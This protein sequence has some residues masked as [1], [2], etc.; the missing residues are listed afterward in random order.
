MRPYLLG[1]KFYIHTDQKSLKH[2]LEQC[3]ATPDQ[4]KW[5]TKLLGYDYEIVYKIGK[6]N[7]TTDAL[8]QVDGNPCLN[9]LFIPQASIW[10]TI[11]KKTSEHP[12][13]IRISKEAIEQLREPYQLRNGL[14]FCK[15]HVVIPPNSSII[16]QVLHEYHD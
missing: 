13:M 15:T 11:K 9:H 16:P 8:S 7:S 2:L 14:V 3:I 6:D 1:L 10:A 12:Y 4:Q 5:I